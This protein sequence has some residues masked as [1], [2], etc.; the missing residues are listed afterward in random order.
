MQSLRPQKERILFNNPK[1][2]RLYREAITELIA[3]KPWEAPLRISDLQH[4]YVVNKRCRLGYEFWCYDRSEK[5]WYVLRPQASLQ[6]N[7]PN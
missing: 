4:R 2:T 7:L 6:P 1:A 3:F 5:E